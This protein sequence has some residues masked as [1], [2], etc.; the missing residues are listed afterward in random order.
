[1]NNLDQENEQLFTV[2]NEYWVKLA[3][4]LESLKKDRRFQNLILNAYFKDKAINGV[5]LLAN[6]AI[7]EQGKRPAIIESLVAISHLEDFL[8]TVENLGTVTIDDEDSDDQESSYER[9]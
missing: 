5:S 2:E 3:E 7:I 6:E 1:M 8:I 9:R 4:D